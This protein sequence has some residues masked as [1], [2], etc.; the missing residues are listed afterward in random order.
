MEVMYNQ[1]R[2]SLYE[3][4]AQTGKRLAH[5]AELIGD[6]NRK[7]GKTLKVVAFPQRENYVPSI[8]VAG[9]WLGRFGFQLGDEVTL[10]AIEGQIVITRKGGSRSWQFPGMNGET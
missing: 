9:K 3:K 10:T 4:R 6:K 8:R 7:T 2:L 1:Q 5:Q